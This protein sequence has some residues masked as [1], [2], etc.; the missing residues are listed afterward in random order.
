VGDRALKKKRKKKSPG[1]SFLALS[2]DKLTYLGLLDL[3]DRFY[4]AT[5]Y[6]PQACSFLHGVLSHTLRTPL[7]DTPHHLPHTN[8][9]P[10][11]LC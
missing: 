6:I 11:H 9:N 3:E 4:L 5:V 10:A 7:A 2:P 8:S 1:K